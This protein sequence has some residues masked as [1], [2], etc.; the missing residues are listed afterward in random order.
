MLHTFVSSQSARLATAKIGVTTMSV[1]VH[2]GLITFAVLASGRALPEL[3]SVRNRAPIEQL[4][5]VKMSDLEHAASR[6]SAFARAAKHVARLI[7]PDLALLRVKVDAS[8]ASLAPA[9]EVNVD[10]DVGSRTGSASDFGPIDTSELLGQSAMWKLSHPGANGAYSSDV[11]ERTAWPE[12]GNPRPR[13]PASLA[14]AGIEASF[15]V[16]FVVDSTG[17]VDAK[18]LNFPKT[19]H[20]MF[21]KAVKDALLHSRYF[22][23]ELAGMRVRQLVQQQFT[24]V[25]GR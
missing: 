25:L 14:R 17:R 4:R 23:A 22:P 3:D 5:F 19:A 9:P 2:A 7:V 8:L 12:S 21:L 6:T 11:V 24:F 16:E 10:L 20:P 1:A 18:T 15:M 13:Y